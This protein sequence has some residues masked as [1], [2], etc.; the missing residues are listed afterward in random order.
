MF[1]E[2]VRRNH[3]RG[4]VEWLFVGRFHHR[5]SSSARRRCSACARHRGHAG[6]TRLLNLTIIAWADPVAG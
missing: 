5:A 2:A 1:D 6:M 3:A 4:S